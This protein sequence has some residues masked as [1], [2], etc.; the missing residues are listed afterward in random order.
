[1]DP[2]NLFVDQRLTGFCVFCG[3]EPQSRD[4]C[5]SK[6]LLDE[7]FPADLDLP[8]VEA[9][10]TCNTSFSKDE[11]YVA[12]LIECALCG[13]AEP[14]QVQRP[15]IKR[16][17]QE[18]PKLT[19]RLQTSRKTDNG[20]QVIWEVDRDRVRQVVLKLAR[21]HIAYELS[22][23]KLEEPHLV[24]FLPFVAMTVERRSAFENPASSEIAPW[25][26]IG[27]RAFLRS[28]VVSNQ[29]YHDDGWIV[30][31][32]GRYRYLVTQTNGDVVQIVFCRVI[33]SALS[34]SSATLRFPLR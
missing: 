21:G 33:P 28:L 31:Q 12:C 17:L 1:M 20:G 5:P 18:N 32:P 22:L 4:H 11:Q 30:V 13:S 26:E 8:V 10:E 7:P 14:A 34:S 24:E 16:I 29:V 15:K 6:V 2:R 3:A 25:P 9:C 19:T 27:S 23:P